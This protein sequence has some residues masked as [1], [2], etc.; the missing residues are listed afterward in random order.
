VRPAPGRLTSNGR[1]SLRRPKGRAAFAAAA[2]R[3]IGVGE[4]NTL[5]AA[6]GRNRR[7]HCSDLL[8]IAAALIMPAQLS[9]P[10]LAG[11]LALPTAG[12]AAAPVNSWAAQ[13]AALPPDLRRRRQ[14]EYARERGA[15]AGRAALV[16][17]GTVLGAVV[18]TAVL[19]QAP[20]QAPSSTTAPSGS[21][22]G[23]S[24]PQTP[25]P[26]TAS[27]PSASP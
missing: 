15:M 8:G 5:A 13:R 21:P 27:T 7:S 22:T 25:S 10:L 11:L 19:L 6:A 3:L 24:P 12:L 14:T 4:H 26:S 17:A 9:G 2:I 23:S 1:V 16:G 18:A 20:G